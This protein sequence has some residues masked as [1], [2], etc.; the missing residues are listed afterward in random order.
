MGSATRPQASHPDALTQE[1]SDVCELLK[2]GGGGRGELSSCWCPGKN[3]H[4]LQAWWLGD[5]GGF[6]LAKSG[7]SPAAGSLGRWG[8][9]ALPF[10]MVLAAP[11]ALSCCSVMAS[12]RVRRA[13]S[14]SVPLGDGTG[15]LDRCSGSV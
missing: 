5:F 7:P 13:T 11:G 3:G 8:S 14:G 9:V 1:P 15:H 12:A 6:V 2:S 10:V 4:R